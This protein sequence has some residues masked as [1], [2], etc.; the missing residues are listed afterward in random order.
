VSEGIY[1][2]IIFEVKLV[3]GL[4]TVSGSIRAGEKTSVRDPVTQGNCVNMPIMFYRR[5]LIL[6]LGGFSF[7]ITIAATSHDL[8][9]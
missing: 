9:D 4:V 8:L 1:S 2:N 6:R 7:G 3:P 5:V